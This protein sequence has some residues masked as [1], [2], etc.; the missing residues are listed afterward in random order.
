MSGLDIIL[1]I[2]VAISVGVGLMRGLIREALSIISWVLAFWLGLSYADW[3]VPLVAKYIPGVALQSGIAFVVVFV[4]S[5]FLFSIVS[6]LLY[7]AIAVK[8][9]QGPDRLL[10]AA[11][12]VL[13]AILLIAILIIVSRGIELNRSEFW[14]ASNFISYFDPTA[15]LISQLLP[16]VVAESPA[17]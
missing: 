3:A 6:Y 4:V 14:L 1:V 17:S 16:K 8:A 11:F 12:G 13:R 2:I 5:L 10:G 15:D 9:I 7:K